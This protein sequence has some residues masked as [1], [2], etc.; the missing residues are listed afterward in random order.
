MTDK[1]SAHQQ[2]LV[3]KQAKRV[4]ALARALAPRVPHASVE[5]LESAGFEGLVQ[6]ALR[7]DA[8]TGVPF[9]TFA[10]YRIRG[11]MID[12][13]RD[14]APQIRRRSRAMRALQTTQALLEQAQKRQPRAEDGEHRTLK[15]RVRAA[16]D[17]VAQA[18]AA[19]VLSKMAP[20]A[21]D[22]LAAG[23]AGAEEALI[24]KERRSAL[25]E[26]LDSCTDPERSMIDG[27][28]FRGLSMGEYA[29]EVGKN[30]S[31]VSRQHAKLLDRL[32]K[33]LK[34][35]LRGTQLEPE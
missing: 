28:Y 13:A 9:K 17:V 12:A 25:S 4:R 22:T 6:A 33:R 23:D 32:S 15:E 30:K 7:F 8:T 16:A 34:T 18:T 29:K 5:E 27:L 19:V 24:D 20:R 11:A 14:A 26:V 35:L 21:P 1:L 31:T 3:E 2:R 10:H